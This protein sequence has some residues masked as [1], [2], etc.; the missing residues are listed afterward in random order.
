MTKSGCGRCVVVVRH[1]ERQDYVTR[2]AGGNWIASAKRPWDPPLTEHGKV[3]ATTVGK[4]L[5]TMLE[6]I[7]MPPTV[8]AVYSSPLLRCRQTAAAIS[9]HASTNLESP[10]KIRAEEG[11]VESLNQGFYRSWA[12]PTSDGTWDHLRRENP[13]DKLIQEP[14]KLHPASK[15]PIQHLINWKDAENDEALLSMMDDAHVSKT[16]LK[17]EYQFCPPEL[18]SFKTQRARMHEAAEELSKAHV[19]ETIVMVSH[20]EQRLMKCCV[21]WCAVR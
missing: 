20:G 14:E 5:R 2:D 1:G 18:E 13:L 7:N 6:K 21:V 19:D 4:N 11:L 17:M 3:Q 15:Q 10:A 9:I 8:S 12:L 16:K